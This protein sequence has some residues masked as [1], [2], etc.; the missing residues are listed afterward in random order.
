MKFNPRGP[1]TDVRYPW[2]PAEYKPFV[3]INNQFAEGK[4]EA[5]PPSS[6]PFIGFDRKEFFKADIHEIEKVIKENYDKVV[7]VVKEAPAEQYRES[8]LMA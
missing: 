4:T 7:D 3:G 5:Y 8:L 2:S 1:A 6:H